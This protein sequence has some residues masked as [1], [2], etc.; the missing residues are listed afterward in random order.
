LTCTYNNY[1]LIAAYLFGL[2]LVSIAVGCM[3]FVFL[4][5][6]PQSDSKRETTHDKHKEGI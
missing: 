3:S 6:Q 5:N 2:G 1:Y 4:K